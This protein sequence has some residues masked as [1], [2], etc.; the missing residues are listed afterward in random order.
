MNGFWNSTLGNIVKDME[1][2]AVFLNS[3]GWIGEMRWLEVV[4][5]FGSIV[6]NYL[7]KLV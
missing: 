2:S 3:N 4:A 6:F 1:K 7:S 5:I